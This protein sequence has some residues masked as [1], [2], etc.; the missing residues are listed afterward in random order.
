MSLRSVSF[1]GLIHGRLLA[2]LSTLF[3]FSKFMILSFKNKCEINT[4]IEGFFMLLFYFRQRVSFLT[5]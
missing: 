2:D 4:V 1:F 5:D 3:K